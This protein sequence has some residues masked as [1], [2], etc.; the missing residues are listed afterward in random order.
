MEINFTQIFGGL[1]IASITWVASQFLSTQNSISI[2]KVQMEQMSNVLTEI[3]SDQKEFKNLYA[4]R[5]D[6]EKLEKRVDKI[7]GRK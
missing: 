2:V 4:L 7:E 5:N 6:L 3:R 1:V